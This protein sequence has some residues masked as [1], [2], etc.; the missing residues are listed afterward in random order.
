[1]K[2]SDLGEG[3][4]LGPCAEQ[5]AKLTEPPEWLEVTLR[6]QAA[7]SLI[8]KSEK[9]SAGNQPRLRTSGNPKQRDTHRR[10]LNKQINECGT[11]S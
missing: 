10:D 11:S 3:Q 8:L 5:P 9:R 7:T 2:K 4:W 6:N 1:M